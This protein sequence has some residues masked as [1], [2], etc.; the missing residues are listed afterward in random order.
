[1]GHHIAQNALLIT[2][3]RLGDAVLSTG[4][5]AAIHAQHPQAKITV[6]CGPLPAPLFEACPFV[7]R[8]IAIR[9]KKRFGHW[10]DL[11]K[12]LWTTRWT[13]IVDLRNSAISR[14]LWAKQRHIL[15]HHIPKDV[16]KVIQYQRVMK[17][18]EP[19]APQLWL[20]AHSDV[21]T[22]IPNGAK[23]LALGPAANW[24]AKTWPE[25]RF[26]ELTKRLLAGPLQGWRV[27]IFAAAPEADQ[28]KNIL[29]AFPDAISAVGWGDPAQV[30]SALSRCDLFI[31]NDSGLMHMA[32]ALNVKTLGLFGPTYDDIY[33][34]WGGKIVR[35]PETVAEL[36]DI[37][38][39]NSKTCPNLMETLSVDAA[40]EA[41][42][43]ML[44]KQ[45]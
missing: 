10:I 45:S 20:P 39:Y 17:L 6:V 35:T 29:A 3:T 19:P 15:D 21:E 24:H 42:S 14:L 16:H 5:L 8:V 4:L 37:P 23:V 18:E 41:V 25:D 36:L 38:D 43:L 33:G 11:W 31:G 7:D 40:E 28:V 32:A 30:A 13:T 12:M 27:A 22:L 9:K 44:L 26:I 1:M 2:S 34:P